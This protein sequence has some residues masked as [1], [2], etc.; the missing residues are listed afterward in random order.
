MYI[1]F[2]DKN[3]L[4]LDV[5]NIEKIKYYLYKKFKN[6]K[7]LLILMKKFHQ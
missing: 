2:I 7:K 1:G 4:E 6:L 5:K 3:I